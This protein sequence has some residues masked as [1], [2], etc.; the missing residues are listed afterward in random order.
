MSLLK[1]ALF[2]L[3]KSPEARLWPCI[4]YILVADRCLLEASQEAEVVA[5]CVLPAI[6]SCPEKKVNA[7][8]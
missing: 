8:G 1:V 7:V 2:L 4:G 3:S 6:W 5:D